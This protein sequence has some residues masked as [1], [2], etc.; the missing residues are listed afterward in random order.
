MRLGSLAAVALL[1]AAAACDGGL[2]PVPV[3]ARTLV[4]ACGTATF[5]D[6]LPDSTDA[7]FIVAFPT[8]PQHCDELL[9]LPPRFRPFPPDELPQPYVDSTTYQLELPPDRYEWV[10]AVWKKVGT[11]TL[12][13]Q[14]TAMFRVAGDYR[15]PADTTQ[16]GVVTIPSGGAVGDVNVRVDFGN[17]RTVDS[18]VPCT[19]Q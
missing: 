13:R 4:G 10:V 15:D 11:P 5:L 7:V 1:V 6:T 18:F 8:F 12:S 3:C 14:D 16:R 2:Q 19:A 17:L 9:T